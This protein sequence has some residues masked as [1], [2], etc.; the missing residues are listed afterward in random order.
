MPKER[1]GHLL[2]KILYN[3]DGDEYDNP[4][5]HLSITAMGA[6]MALCTGEVYG[7]GEGAAV[8]EN[9]NR[10]RGGITCCRCLELIGFYKSIK[11]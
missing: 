8:Y 1:K 2:V 10:V 5:W 11:L 6:P 4:K 7:Y 9:K 3:D